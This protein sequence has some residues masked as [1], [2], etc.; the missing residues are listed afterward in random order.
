MLGKI[1][2]KLGQKQDVFLMLCEVYYSKLKGKRFLK[3]NISANKF[4]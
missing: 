1:L 4:G 3:C 2:R